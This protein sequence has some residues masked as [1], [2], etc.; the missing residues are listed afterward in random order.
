MFKISN[1]TLVPEFGIT[2]I[3]GVLRST[4]CHGIIHHNNEKRP[5]LEIKRK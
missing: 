4:S 3:Y 2:V 5:K 1:T